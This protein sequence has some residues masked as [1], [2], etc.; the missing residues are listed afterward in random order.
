MGKGTGKSF[1]SKIISQGRQEQYVAQGQQNTRAAC[2][3]DKLEF[4]FFKP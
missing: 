4:S 3:R 1:T 2:L